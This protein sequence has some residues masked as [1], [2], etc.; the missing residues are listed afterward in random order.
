[1]EFE[2]SAIDLTQ[3]GHEVTF[4]NL[5]HHPPSQLNTLLTQNNIPFY[6]L[7]YTSKFQYFQTLFRIYRLLKKLQPDIVHCHLLEATL[8][9]LRAARWAGVKK[10]IYTRHHSISH[11]VS[12]PHAIKYDKWANKTA[13][14]IIAI[15]SNVKDVLITKEDVPAD[16]ISLVYHG[17]RISDFTDVS[18]SDVLMLKDKYQLTSRFPVIGCVSRYDEWKGLQYTIEAFKDLLKKYP[19]AKLVLANAGKGDYV[20]EIHL[21]LKELPDGSYIEIPFENRIT[22]LYKC[23][24]VLIHVPTDAYSEAFGQV[25]IEAMA[26][27]IPLIA[28]RSG[29]GSEILD[30]LKN[31]Y[32]VGYNDPKEI[33]EG[34]SFLLSHPDKTKEIV[35]TAFD[36]VKNNFSFDRKL[37][38]LLNIYQSL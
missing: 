31:A 23:M 17:I 37:L 32:V 11:H 16:K 38:T 14:R 34:V 24:D 9:G 18:S 30:H 36:L 5:F 33:A 15:S 7:K 29:I 28:T 12:A 26:A 2:R 25:Y 10:A 19:S 20:K 3:A 13:S 1:M 22:A 27:E 21:L 35:A 4:I 6:E 8:I